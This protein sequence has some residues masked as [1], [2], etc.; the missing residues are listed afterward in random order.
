MGK[1]PILNAAIIMSTAWLFT[2]FSLAFVGRPPDAWN[3]LFDV[4]TISM[5]LI[6]AIRERGL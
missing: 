5:L 4:S 3:L 6:S 2:D 1:R